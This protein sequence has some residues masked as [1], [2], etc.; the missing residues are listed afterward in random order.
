MAIPL[1]GM[2]T[3]P[4]DMDMDTATALDTSTRGALIMGSLCTGAE[5]PVTPWS[6]PPPTLMAA[7]L[8][9]D[10][11]PLTATSL[12]AMPLTAMPHTA[13]PLT[14]LATDTATTTLIPTLLL[15][16]PRFLT[17]AIPLTPHIPPTPP[18]PDMAT[19]LEA[20]GM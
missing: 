20:M 5:L 11:T 17:L 14:T 6:P 19:L 12:T 15:P 7:P 3:L 1:M 16:T 13:L 10:L 9:M 8:P 18:P 4:M 2:D